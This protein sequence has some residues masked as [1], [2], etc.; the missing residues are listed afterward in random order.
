MSTI[1]GLDYRINDMALRIR[2]LREIMGFL[3]AE[4]AQKTGVSEKTFRAAMEGV[5]LYSP[6]READRAGIVC[7]NLGDLSSSEA[8]DAFSRRGI[9]VRGGL[10]CAPGA[11]RFLG[12]LR[13][14]AV[15][16]SVGH[17][18]TFGEAEAFLK[19]VSEIMRGGA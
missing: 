19:S 9:A 7:F 2:E 18:N 5:T 13:R 14:G 15:R 3:P 1:S 16:L 17:A 4:M 8:A 12:T 10:H 11:H 6:R